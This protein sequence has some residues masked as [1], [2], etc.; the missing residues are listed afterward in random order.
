MLQ[1]YILK[2]KQNNKYVDELHMY[3]QLD[4]IKF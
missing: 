2:I 3:Y 1:I 4:K